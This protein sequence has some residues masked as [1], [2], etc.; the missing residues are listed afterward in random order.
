MGRHKE[1]YA[2]KRDADRQ[3]TIIEQERIRIPL[4][5]QSGDPGRPVALS[6]TMQE[7]ESLMKSAHEALQ[8][9]RADQLRREFS[10]RESDFWQREWN[11]KR[12][13]G[14]RDRRIQQLDQRNKELEGVIERVHDVVH[15]DRSEAVDLSERPNIIHPTSNVAH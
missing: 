7:L 15:P 9:Y 12:E 14:E 10:K 1:T 8:R 3:V 5:I 4:R 6:L 2:A 11:L 13:L